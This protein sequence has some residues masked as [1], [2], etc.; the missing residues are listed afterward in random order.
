MNTGIW[1][2]TRE[3][4]IIEW[5]GRKAGMRTIY[6]GAER[7]PR[8]EGEKSKR[9]KSKMIGFDYASSQE[10]RF[11]HDLKKYFRSIMAAVA[12]SDYLYL[13]GPA[14]AKV[15]LEKEMKKDLRLKSIILKVENC[16]SMTDNQ[17]M[18][19][20]INFYKSRTKSMRRV[21]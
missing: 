14:E 4:K 9:T 16:D 7:K 21:K 1:I 20:V 2:D 5:D 19:K 10:A 6:S 18:E 17:L 12:G 8:I 11:R 13:L 3:A 15:W